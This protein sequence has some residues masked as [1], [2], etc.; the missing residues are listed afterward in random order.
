MYLKRYLYNTKKLFVQNLHCP[1][2][3][4]TPSHVMRGDLI[5]PSSMGSIRTPAKFSSTTHIW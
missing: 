2:E 5:E 1:D 4:W 3:M